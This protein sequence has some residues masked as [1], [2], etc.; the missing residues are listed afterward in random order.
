MSDSDTSD[1]DSDC[2][3]IQDDFAPRKTAAPPSS[4]STLYD[5]DVQSELQAMMGAGGG[6][7]TLVQRSS[8]VFSRIGGSPKIAS[9]AESRLSS[10]A[11]A[12]PVTPKL[13]ASKPKVVDQSAKY[14]LES[15]LRKPAITSE[16]K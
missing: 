1:S 15:M 4:V 9:S 7:S 10:M 13:V 6:E 3:V 11:K 8:A 2:Q 14:E 5:A 16:E 12:S